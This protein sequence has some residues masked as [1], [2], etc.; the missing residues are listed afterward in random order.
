[1]YRLNGLQKLIKEQSLFNDR[2]E[3]IQNLTNNIK[4]NIDLINGSIIVLGGMLKDLNKQCTIHRENIIKIFKKKI[5]MITIRFKELLDERGKKMLENKRYATLF[6]GEKQVERPMVK[7]EQQSQVLLQAKQYNSN[8]RVEAVQQ[9]ESTM[10]E[11]NGIMQQLA[12]LTDEQDEMIQSIDTEV[13]NTLTNVERAQS[14]LLKYLA[15]VSS[16]RGLITKMF[17]VLIV[18]IVT[19]F[20]FLF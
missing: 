4:N 3:D 2:L 10:V 1:M 16:N 11:L 20:V 17:L 18:F 12:Q 19:F 9:I 6:L 5:S 13:Q 15:S 7:Q 8:A 14:E